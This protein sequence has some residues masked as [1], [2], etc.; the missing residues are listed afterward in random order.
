VSTHT[1]RAPNCAQAAYK[2]SSGSPPGLLVGAHPVRKAT[3]WQ[4]F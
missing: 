1:R 2:N 4:G 3:P